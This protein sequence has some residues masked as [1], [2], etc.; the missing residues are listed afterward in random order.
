MRRQQTY[1]AL[2]GGAATLFLV[3]SVALP[4]GVIAGLC[5]MAAG[6]IAVLSC[7]GITA[8]GPGEQ[9]GAVAQDRFLDGVRAPQGDWPPYDPDRVVEGELVER[10]D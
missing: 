9:A 10:P 2:R 7:I 4:K 1:L 5:V 6:I 8:G 3:S